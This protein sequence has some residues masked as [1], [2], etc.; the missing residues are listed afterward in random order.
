[1]FIIFRFIY[2]NIILILKE[3]IIY[4]FQ[5]LKITILIDVFL[6]RVLTTILHKFMIHVIWS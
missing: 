3:H 1:M 4:E 2:V 5:V 6:C